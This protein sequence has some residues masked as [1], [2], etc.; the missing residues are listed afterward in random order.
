[1]YFQKGRCRKKR[2]HYG[3]TEGRE[4]G[5]KETGR[6]EPQRAQRTRRKKEKYGFGTRTW[7]RVLGA[8][9]ESDPSRLP[10]SE[11]PGVGFPP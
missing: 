4:T 6:T 7:I 2:V 10:S 1:M 11:G 3:D 9:R 5:G 8:W